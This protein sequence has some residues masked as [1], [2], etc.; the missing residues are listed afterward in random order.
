MPTKSAFVNKGTSYLELTLKSEKQ[1]FLPKNT[2][3]YM[4]C[5]FT[6]LLKECL[7][8]VKADLGLSRAL[9]SC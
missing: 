4:N 8:V 5:A 2:Q 3:T 7:M 1:S 6:A 9:S